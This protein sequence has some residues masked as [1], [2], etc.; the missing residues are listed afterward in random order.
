MIKTSAPKKKSPAAF[1][2]CRD[3]SNFEIGSNTIA[4]IIISPG[5]FVNYRPLGVYVSVIER[6]QGQ[7]VGLTGMIDFRDDDMLKNSI[8]RAVR[9]SRTRRSPWNC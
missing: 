9:Q 7:T 8:Q 4:I 5:A 2:G 1:T 6:F 3:W